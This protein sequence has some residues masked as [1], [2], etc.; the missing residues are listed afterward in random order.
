MKVPVV[1]KEKQ[2]EIQQR[3]VKGKKLV[4]VTRYKEVDETRLEVQYHTINGIQEKRAVP[5]TTRRKIP[6]RD[7]EEKEVSVTVQVPMEEVV[8]RKGHRYDKH[9]VSKIVEV[10]EDHHYEMR[11]VLVGKGE[12]RMKDG[13]DHHAFKK[14]HGKA[15]WHDDA[16]VGWNGRPMT[17]PHNDHLRRPSSA[18]SIWSTST[19]EEIYGPG[20]P[21]HSRDAGSSMT[22][23]RLRPGTSK[24]QG[25]LSRTQFP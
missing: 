20:A 25:A 14:T 23:S 11:P 22:K 24:S 16:E 19:R 2:C 10:E 6:Y 5:V 3:I 15:V 12:I 7:Y 17:P 9:V 13:G 1:R 4:P 21:P 18:G 8:T